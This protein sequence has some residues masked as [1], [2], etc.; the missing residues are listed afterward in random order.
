MTMIVFSGLDCSGKS[1]QIEIL[2]NKLDNE[3][4]KSLIFWSR[5]GYTSGMQF[6][7]D[8][9]RKIGGKKLPTP[10]KSE[11]RTEGF[12]N[13]KVRKIWLTLALFDLIFYYAIYLRFKTWM[14]NIVICDRYMMDTAIDFKLNFPQENVENWFLWKI[15]K[16]VSL[17][18]AIHFVST[19]PVPVSVERSKHKFEPF[20]DSPEVLKLRLDSYL[21]SIN[22]NPNLIYIDGLD[23]I[24]KVT[25][26]VLDALSQKRIN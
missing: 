11:K 2:K 15:L 23:P 24:K 20:P 10:G 1:T 14:G 8:L 26:Q 4:K 7:K 25:K 22:S 3:N 6:L 17:K 18:P 21:N 9:V 13:S 5:G 12:K 16:S 19:I